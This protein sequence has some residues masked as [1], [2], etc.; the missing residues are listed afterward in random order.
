MIRNKGGEDLLQ[1]DQNRKPNRLINE[2]SPYLL[3]HAYNPVNWYPWGEEAFSLAEESEKPVFLSIGYSTCHWCHV[4]AHESFEDYQVAEMLNDAF[5]PVKVDREERPDIDNIY[6]SVCQMMT[7]GGGWPLTIVMTPDKKPFFAAT[8]IPKDN[9]LGVTG[10]LNLIPYLRQY[11]IFRK[12]EALS[13]AGRIVSGL[14]EAS[15]I[16]VDKE[17]DDLVLERAYNELSLSYDSVFGGFGTSPKFPMMH[18]FL[19]LLKFRNRFGEKRSLEMVEKSI[20]SMYAGGIYDH[21]GFGFHR[22]STD[23][24]WL[25]PHFEKMLYDQAMIAF[26]SISAFEITKK[27]VYG[28]IALEIFEFVMRDMM[29]DDGGFYSAIDADSEGEEGKFYLWTES[30]IRDVLDSGEAEVFIRAFGVKKEGNYIDHLSGN[31]MSFNILHLGESVEVL[32][33]HL[34]LESKIIEEIIF[35]SRKKLFKKRESRIHPFRDEKVLTDWNGLMAAAFAKGGKILNEA[36]YIILAERTINFLMNNMKSS[37][38]S[39]LHI[40]KSGRSKIKAMADDYAFLTW[41]LIELY[42]AGGRETYLSMAV[43]LT[44]QFIEKFWDEEKGGFYIASSDGE[45]LII[46]KKDIYD[47]ALPSSNSVSLMNL[48]RLGKLTGEAS[49]SRKAEQLVRAFSSGVSKSPSGYTFFLYA[50]DS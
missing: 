27:P 21:L 5:I 1:D 18:N 44:K 22:Y 15:G 3:Q 30:E 35:T 16:N 42:E 9:R 43:N 13:V 8:Y 37:D 34:N 23:R 12:G 33:S 26:S 2:L 48:L 45:E 7:G 11:W 46:R 28:K 36:R 25:V 24:E 10:L 32:A 19:F 31:E 29:S 47:G 17:I 39:L 14:K 49:F 4:M 6:M 41:G 50:M 20:G 38:G 40:F